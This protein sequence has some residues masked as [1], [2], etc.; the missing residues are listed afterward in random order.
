M[1]QQQQMKRFYCQLITHERQQ[2]RLYIFMVA[3]VLLVMQIVTITFVD[4]LRKT[5]KAYVVALQVAG[6]EVEHSHL[7]GCMH[8]FISVASISDKAK[9]A[10]LDIARKLGVVK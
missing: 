5:G 3:A 6:V 7:E 1:W 2:L 4:Y 8:G 9:Q 10:C